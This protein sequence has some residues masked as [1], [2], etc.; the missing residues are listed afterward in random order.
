[1]TNLCLFL[2]SPFTIHGKYTNSTANTKQEQAKKNS[3]IHK[4]QKMI[5][6]RGSIRGKEANLYY[7]K[8]K[9]CMFSSSKCNKHT[10][11]IQFIVDGC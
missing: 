7:I 3:C 10:Y 5:I 6:V 4:F 8:L 2:I 11:R 9:C 1:M